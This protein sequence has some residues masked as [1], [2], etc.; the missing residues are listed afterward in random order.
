MRWQTAMHERQNA[1]ARQPSRDHRRAFAIAAS[2]R[3]DVAM[4]FVP[5]GASCMKRVRY[6]RASAGRSLVGQHHP[7]IEQQIVVPAAAG[8]R[9]CCHASMAAAAVVSTS[10]APSP[11][12]ASPYDGSTSTARGTPPRPRPAAPVLQLEQSEVEP[13]AR[14]IG[15]AAPAVRRTSSARRD[16]AEA[17]V[18]D[19]QIVEQLGI[20]IAGSPRSFERAGRRPSDRRPLAARR[21]ASP[22]ICGNW[23]WSAGASRSSVTAS[24]A[25]RASSTVAALVRAVMKSGRSRRWR[26]TRRGPHGSA[27]MLNA[28]SA[29]LNRSLSATSR[30]GSSASV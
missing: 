15:I 30:F 18:G 17:G 26:G 7:E 20:L 1:E 5:R 9:A 12:Q 28:S 27:A 13:G 2:T 19:G 4:H 24:A 23:R 16:A 29:V 25:R 6:G 10:A 11:C 22:E 8:A 14:R 21:R 3:R